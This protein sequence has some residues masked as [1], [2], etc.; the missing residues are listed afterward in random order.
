MRNILISTLLLLSLSAENNI[1]M[2]QNISKADKVEKQLKKQMDREKK[3][4]QEQTFYQ[5][6]DYD[7]S[8]AEIDKNSLDNIKLPE[9]DYDFDMD[10]V[11]D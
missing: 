5:G 8:Y 4:A 1:S 3:F 11:Y 6:K 7:L 2:E 10:D 9:P